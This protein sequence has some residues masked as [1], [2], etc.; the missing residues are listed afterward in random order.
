MAALTYYF[1]YQYRRRYNVRDAETNGELLIDN[2]YIMSPEDLCKID[3]LDQLINS[4]IDILK[5]EGRSK[6]ADY[7]YT[8]TKCYREAWQAI[9]KG[10]Y[11][12]D[13]IENWKKNWQQFLTV[14]SGRDIN[15]DV[16]WVNG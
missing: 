7:V 5:I 11:N 4:G 3:I 14:V 1:Y 15:W 13:K 9:K 12:P 10:D 2:E 6:G 8:V 16:S